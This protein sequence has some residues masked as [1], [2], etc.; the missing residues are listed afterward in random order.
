MLLFDQ[1]PIIIDTEMQNQKNLEWYSTDR[2][3]NYM[4]NS[5][6]LLWA[7]E[8]IDYS[9]N[10]YGYRTGEIED[11][12]LSD[13]MLTFGCSYTEGVGLH[14]YQIWNYHLKN[15]LNLDL[16]NLGKQATGMD[17]QAFNTM[18]WIQ[19][20]MPLPKLVVIQ[21]PHKSRKLFAVQEPEGIAIID[22][23]DTMCHDNNWWKKRYIV[24]TSQMHLDVL[25]WFELANYAWKSVNVP[26][27]NFTWDDDLETVLKDSKFAIHCINPTVKD[28]ARDGIH[29]GPLIHEQT[30]QMLLEIFNS[31]RFTHKV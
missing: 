1:G 23:S 5:K 10:K 29:D 24:D 9:F 25:T 7:D 28:R 16:H 17:V 21:W 8:E 31:G 14:E 12:D 26:V 2:Y 15:Q 30:A 18:R 11:I 19:S 6:R 3:I 22:K 20:K 4:K 13:F 27:I